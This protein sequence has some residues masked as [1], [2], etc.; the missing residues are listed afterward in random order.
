MSTNDDPDLGLG[1]QM[2]QE[3]LIY[4]LIAGILFVFAYVILFM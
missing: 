1:K 2:L 3:A 4:L